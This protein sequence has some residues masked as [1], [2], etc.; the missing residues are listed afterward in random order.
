MNYYQYF[1]TEDIV[2][3]EKKVDMKVKKT[4]HTYHKDRK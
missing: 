1:P 2:C 3:L 4:T